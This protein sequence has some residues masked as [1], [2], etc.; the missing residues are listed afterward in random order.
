VVLRQGSGEPLVLLHGILGS[1]RM[2]SHVVP[3]LAGHY[4]V[5]APTMLGH[6]GGRPA[7]A[8]PAR[9]EHVVA[10]AQRLLDG[11]GLETVH[12]AGNSLGGQV[13]LELARLGRAR[14]V[15]ALSPSGTWQAGSE[16]HRRATEVL[17]ATVR[18]ARR[19]RRVLPLLVRSGRFRRWA[20]RDTAAH[21]ERVSPAELLGLTD[22][23][24]GCT[25]VEDLFDEATR[26]APLD[27]PPCPITLAWAGRDCVFPVEINGARAREL[28]GGVRWIVLGDVGHV[29]MLDDP[30]LV[31]QTILTV[32]ATESHDND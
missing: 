6:R 20:L 14:T 18:A 27:P 8:R 4:D 21:G 22:D 10:D 32:T 11:L 19:S 16:D 7:A 25:V 23:L 28:I 1:E 24:L 5:I 9:L 12:L 15:C 17:R 30:Q 2:W 13:A 26:L 31:A 3:L 29:P